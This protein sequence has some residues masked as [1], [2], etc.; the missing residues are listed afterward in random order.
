MDRC[1]FPF[2][3]ESGYHLR[4]LDSF[5][6][7]KDIWFGQRNLWV[8]NTTYWSSFFFSFS[9]KRSQKYDW[10][11]RFSMKYY[12]IYPD[13]FKSS[14]DNAALLVLYLNKLLYH[15]DV[16]IINLVE[17]IFIYSTSMINSNYDSPTKTI[18]KFFLLYK[19]NIASFWN[20]INLDREQLGI[21][22]NL[23][24]N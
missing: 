11:P 10:F 8:K 23:K 17:F 3:V 12:E 21:I 5:D 16:K 20:I 1:N 7:E 14:K 13:Y 15:C 19:F 18:H 22:S 9:D 2:V 24:L 4:T 6:C